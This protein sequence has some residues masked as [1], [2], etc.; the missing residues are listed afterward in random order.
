MN[1]IISIWLFCLSII[2]VNAQKLPENKALLRS[3]PEKEGVSSQGI[4]NYLEAVKKNGL[5]LHSI[6]I[7]RN[8]KVVA[9]HWFGDNG[10]GINHIMHSVSKTFISTAIGFAAAENRIKVSDKV[11]SF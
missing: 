2:A 7:L 6:M 8:G 1:K 11:I 3:T 10:P 9:E 4:S 5:E